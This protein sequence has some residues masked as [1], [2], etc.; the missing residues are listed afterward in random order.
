MCQY[1]FQEQ[2]SRLLLFIMEIE[3][4]FLELLGK[5]ERINKTDSGL[6]AAK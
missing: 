1:L 3:I 5:L 6:H 4:T 2:E